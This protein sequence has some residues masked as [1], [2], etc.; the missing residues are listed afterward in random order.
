MTNRPI[1]LI[2]NSLSTN[3]T[4]RYYTNGTF[5]SSS[6]TTNYS[7]TLAYIGKRVNLGSDF[8]FYHGTILELCIYT[9]TTLTTNQI[10]GLHNYTKAIYGISP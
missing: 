8:N 2:R 1:D 3:A 7:Y 9:N 10:V 5:I 4:A 6:V